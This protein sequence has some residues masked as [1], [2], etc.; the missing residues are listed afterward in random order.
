MIVNDKKMYS[1][2]EMID[3]GADCNEVYF[4]WYGKRC[5]YQLDCNEKCPFYNAENMMKW[6]KEGE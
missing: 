3:C 4:N 5:M 6:L 2:L 1:L